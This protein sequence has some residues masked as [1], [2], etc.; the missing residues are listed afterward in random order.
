[1][2]ISSF[3]S[4]LRRRRVFRVA[5]VYAVI[6]WLM[7]QIAETVFP[8]LLIPDWAVR[9]VIVLSLL[10]LPIAV[11]LAWAYEL[12]PD[13]M[14]R[15]APKRDEG[16]APPPAA[17]GRG[18]ALPLAIA[19]SVAVLLGIVLVAG[20]GFMGGGD[21]AP[22]E[23]RPISSIAVLAFEDMSPAQDQEYFGDG[24]A[25]ELLDALT[26]I[27]GLEVASRTSAFSFKGK[28]ARIGEIASVLGVQ[29]VLEGSVRTS[30]DQL[31][32]T[33]QLIDAR[34]DR[35]LWSETYT[36]DFTD[37]FLVQDSISRSIV[38]ALRGT[39]SRS[40]GS[41]ISAGTRD[42]EAYRLFL[43]G[44]H[45][46]RRGG[47]EAAAEAIRMLE[48]AIERDSE[49]AEAHEVLAE[50]YTVAGRHSDA[51]AAATRA[52]ELAALGPPAR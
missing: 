3:V 49:Y 30:G 22:A 32:V 1:M 9:L 5:G 17:G 46:L 29:A 19:G 39:L 26:R 43:Q 42:A 47:L 6:A 23:D 21:A 37:I 20:Y 8:Y 25:E 10:G 12:T 45:A 41:L 50:A 36:R 24:I 15:A 31:R 11:V 34:T 2:D 27:P 48:Q 40:R 51:A 52:G 14:Q 35:H 13:G 38:G 44:R 4:E 18:R 33:A 28:G 7:I 16:A